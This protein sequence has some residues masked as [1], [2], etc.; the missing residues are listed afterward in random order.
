MTAMALDGSWPDR[1]E[2]CAIFWILFG[3]PFGMGM[4]TALF[5]VWVL[6]WL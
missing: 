6:G 1:R 4:S 2:A 3:T 5:W